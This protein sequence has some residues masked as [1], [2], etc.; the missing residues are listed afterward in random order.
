[1]DAE[2]SGRCLYLIWMFSDRFGMVLGEN[3]AENSCCEAAVTAACDGP[4]A[5]RG[6]VSLLPRGP[7]A[8]F[9]KNNKIIIISF[10]L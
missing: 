6:K 7:R 3:W 9:K 1:M 4:P 2:V 8:P 10:N 5:A